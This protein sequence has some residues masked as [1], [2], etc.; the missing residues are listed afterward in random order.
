MT[1]LDHRA[2]AL[3]MQGKFEP[4]IKDA[5][6]MISFGP[7]L[8]A[9]YIRLVHLFDMQGKQ[10]DA[11]KVYRQALKNVPNDNPAYELLVQG[12]KKAIEK[13]EQRIDPVSILPS[14]LDNIIFPLLKEYE[15]AVL[16]DVS[17]EW[18]RRI[19]NSH[20]AWEE[21]VEFNPPNRDG[22]VARAMPYVGKHVEDLKINTG[23]LHLVYKYFDCMENGY[24]T[25][26]KSLTLNYS[27]GT[28]ITT[29]AMMLWTN[30]LWR[31]RHTLTT[32]D[33][34]ACYFDSPIRLV[35][36]LTYSPNLKTFRFKTSRDFAYLIKDIDLLGESTTHGLIDL[37][38]RTY[39]ISGSDL[40]LLVERCPH[41]R[42]LS[43]KNC[44]PEVFD[45]VCDHCPN[46]EIFGFDPDVI[47]PELDELDNYGN[48]N[49]NDNS[50]DKLHS[51]G[52]KVLYTPS[53]GKCG[54]P[55]DKLL[56][57]LWKNQ[58][59]LKHIYINMS[60]TEDQK[61]N[62]EPH[63]NFRPSYQYQ[64]N[65]FDQLEKFYYLGD[66]Y[67]VAEPIFFQAM[68]PCL[69]Y[70]HPMGPSNIPAL[71]DC[72]VSLPPVQKLEFT[73]FSPDANTDTE[74]SIKSLVR[75]FKTYATTSLSESNK[76]LEM[77]SYLDSPLVMTDEV[78]DALA[79][80]KTIKSIKFASQTANVTQEGLKNFFTKVNKHAQLTEVYLI[81][82]KA[83]D[84][85]VL[86]AI[87]ELDWLHTLY[88]ESLLS[89]KDEGVNFVVN[90]SKTVTTFNI[91]YCHKVTKAL[92]DDVTK[93]Y[94]QTNIYID[95][96]D[97]DDD[98][99][100]FGLF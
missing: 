84:D 56:R 47:I 63:D 16:M 14:Q 93:S 86:D 43:L 29:N 94:K 52:L 97:D 32:L 100:G 4:A 30:A 60:M 83:V 38:L 54:V 90:K 41:L 27:G 46:L 44:E 65:S 62:Q 48:D 3:G 53:R 58:H 42:R 45:V 26:I 69:T 88:C 74:S 31:T 39:N 15:R 7:T 79:E 36:I 77:F 10:P 12:E 72:L 11:I 66:I 57:L 78:L 71:V 85:E 99:L 82:T 70:F 40:K 96:D 37:K 8:D 23:A 28:M 98:S 5:E 17:K 21:I 61:D 80:V 9:G 73:Q 18:R 19:I 89:I 22:I 1:V 34:D 95:N 33:I 87:S 67:R 68:R 2:Y 35:D 92:V 13:N 55:A 59:S 50:N 51:P 76:K 81:R 6:K 75:L 91:L 20:A 49:D 24:L 64:P 25:N